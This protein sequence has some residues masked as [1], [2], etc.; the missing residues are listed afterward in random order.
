METR[1]FIALLKEHGTIS[2]GVNSFDPSEIIATYSLDEDGNLFTI[3]ETDGTKELLF[4][5]SDEENLEQ[6]QDIV[7]D[8][9]VSHS[10]DGMYEEH[11]KKAIEYVKEHIHKRVKDYEFE[12]AYDIMDECRCPLDHASDTIVDAIRDLMDDYTLDEDLPEDWWYEYTDIEDI[13]WEL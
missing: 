10:W 8:D 13:F 12:R 6:L 5:I 2:V 3:D 7:L 11:L 1:E 4:N 9:V